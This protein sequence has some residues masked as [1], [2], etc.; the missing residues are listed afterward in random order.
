MDRPL[1]TPRKDYGSGIPECKVLGVE[2]GLDEEGLE[3]EWGLG[4]R[5]Q[6]DIGSSPGTPDLVWQGPL[7]YE[8]DDPGEQDAARVHWE[9]G[10]AGPGAASRMASA[11]WSR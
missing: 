7:D 11:G 2:D 8:D 1:G 4:V 9:E 3:G 10:K 6:W 5:S